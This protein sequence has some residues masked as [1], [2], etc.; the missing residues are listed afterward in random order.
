MEQQILIKQSSSELNC[1][2]V[3]FSKTIPLPTC[4]TNNNGPISLDRLCLDLIWKLVSLLDIRTIVRLGRICNFFKALELLFNGTFASWLTDG[5]PNFNLDPHYNSYKQLMCTLSI[6][7]ELSVVPYIRH[8]YGMLIKNTDNWPSSDKVRLSALRVL[9]L[10]KVRFNSQWT[11]KLLY[12]SYNLRNLWSLY[13]RGLE[14]F[15]SKKK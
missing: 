2:L 10:E 1:S 14:S 5:Q 9:E 7:M 12:K 6:N 8:I 4:E 11:Q 15:P 13:R 3:S